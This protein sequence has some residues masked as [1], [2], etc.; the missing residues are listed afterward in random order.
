MN[1]DYKM[2]VLIF[3]CKN[4]TH[5]KLAF[6]QSSIAVALLEPLTGI[7][8]SKYGGLQGKVRVIGPILHRKCLQKQCSEGKIEGTGR[9]GRRRNQ[10]LA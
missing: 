4:Q 7:R 1:Q 6:M 2:I 8:G 5:T 10:L 3:D 9:R